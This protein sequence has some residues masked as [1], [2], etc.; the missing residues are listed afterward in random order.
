MATV[1]A[2][3]GGEAADTEVQSPTTPDESSVDVRRAREIMYKGEKALKAEEFDKARDFVRQADRY[4]NDTVRDEMRIVVERIDKAETQLLVADAVQAANDGKC[5]EALE[6]TAALI[7]L[8]GKGPSF[9]GFVHQF[10]AEQNADC[11]LG[12]LEKAESLREFRQLAESKN[13]K[14]ALGPKAYATVEAGLTEAVTTRLQAAVAGPMEAKDWP[15]VVAALEEMV[16]SG[17]ASAA[18]VKPLFDQ[19]VAAV[20]EE[21]SQA[22]QEGLDQPL[23]A[24][25]ALKK[26]D[27]LMA[28]VWKVDGGDGSKR[29]F[30]LEPVPKKLAKRRAELEFGV[31]CAAVRC[32]EA[33]PTAMW[34]FGHQSLSPTMEPKAEGKRKLKHGTKVWQIATGA[35]VTLI[36]RKDPGK[37]D[38]LAARIKPAAGWIA[39]SGLRASDTSNIMPP[40]KAMVG[41]RVWGPLRPKQKYYEM[42]TVTKVEGGQATVRRMS[43]GQETKIATTRLRLGL[44]EKG[45]KVLAMCGGGFDLKE[46]IVDS[47]KDTKFASQGDPMV[48]VTC[49]DDDGKPTK[50]K[51]EELMGSLR[52]KP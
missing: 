1:V 23:G 7:D 31:V 16:R 27:G 8:G 15:K 32:S 14:K 6:T 34:V 39:S 29:A 5:A 36:A 28:I 10:S 24:P 21:V 11:L 12:M 3:C 47:V 20:A 4:A 41:V 49:L 52:V 38:G 46:A 33:T 30:E 17:D 25:A 35:G 44:V 2:A 48:K 18:N 43:D 50:E 51:R 42:G 9:D 45:M 37:L 40:G 13:A 26:V 19:V 22:I